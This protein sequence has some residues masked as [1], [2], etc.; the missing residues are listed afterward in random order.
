VLVF[1]DPQI[2]SIQEEN[3]N[4]IKDNLNDSFEKSANDSCSSFP[5]Y[6]WKKIDEVDDLQI[7]SKKKKLIIMDLDND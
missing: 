4:E 7:N 6:M 3:E 1:N 2:T 5:I